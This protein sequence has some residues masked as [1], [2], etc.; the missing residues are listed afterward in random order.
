M[1]GRCK[2]VCWGLWGGKERCGGENRDMGACW[3]VGEV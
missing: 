1:W 3:N 2:E